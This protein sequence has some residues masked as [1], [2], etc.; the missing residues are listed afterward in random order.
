MARRTTP[1]ESAQVAHVKTQQEKLVAKVVLARGLEEVCTTGAAF[2]CGF[3]DGEASGRVYK[4]ER[5]GSA[6]TCAGSE[7]VYLQALRVGGEYSFP[8]RSLL[9]LSSPGVSLSAQL[10]FSSQ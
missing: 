7:E 10:R 3:T 5:W 6:Y 4:W 9:T 2:S 1:A 8:E